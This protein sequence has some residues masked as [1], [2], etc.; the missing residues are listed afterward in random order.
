MPFG[1]EPFGVRG[2]RQH[3]GRQVR[4]PHRLARRLPRLDR[5][6]VDLEAELAEPVRHR[7]G[8]PL[9]VGARVQQALAQQRAAV[10]DP[11]AEHVQVLVLA[12]DR[13]DLRGRHHADAVD[14]AGGERLVDA[15]DGV[16]VGQGEQLDT[17]LR[18]VL[19]DLRSRKLP[20][21]V[22][23]VRLQVERRGAHGGPHISA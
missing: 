22:D 21:R 10:V 4:P 20:V 13:R 2:V 17:G 11:V 5:R 8:A 3:S 9:A 7:V 18:G 12:V 1:G 19:H 16:V 6:R 14:G 15:V 23:G